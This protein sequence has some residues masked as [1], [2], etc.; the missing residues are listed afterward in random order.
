MVWLML[1]RALFPHPGIMGSTVSPHPQNPYTDTVAPSTLLGNKAV[2]DGISY[3][4][5]ILEETRSL[6]QYDCVLIRKGHLDLDTQR[7]LHVNIKAEIGGCFYKAK[8]IKDSGQPG[9]EAGTRP[10]CLSHEPATPGPCTLASRTER[11]CILSLAPASRRCSVM[12][13]LED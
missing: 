11:Q 5:V 9:R 6:T 10:I 12:I 1:G 4:E 2:T 3:D 7:E 8:D 13:A